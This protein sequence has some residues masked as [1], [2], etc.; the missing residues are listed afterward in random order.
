MDRTYAA[1]AEEALA[2]DLNS[3]EA[4]AVLDRLVDDPDLAPGTKLETFI[5]LDMLLGLN[6]EALIGRV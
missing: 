4:L 6:L 2:N 3:P 5:H 1:K